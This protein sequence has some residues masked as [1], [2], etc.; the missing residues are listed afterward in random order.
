MKATPGFWFRHLGAWRCLSLRKETSREEQLGSGT[1]TY[2]EQLRWRPPWAFRGEMSGKSWSSGEELGLEMDI[3]EPSNYSWRPKPWEWVI[4]PQKNVHNERWPSENPAEHRSLIR[5][6]W[7]CLSPAFQEA[8][9]TAQLH[10]NLLLE[11]RVPQ[12]GSKNER[13]ITV[14]WERQQSKHKVVLYVASGSGNT[15]RS[16]D[17]SPE[18]PCGITLLAVS[19]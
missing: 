9:P 7:S 6:R 5:D 8:K 15:A 18:R 2:L 12:Q 10:A 3:W 1:W 4:L 17:T 11:D 14:R 16:W 19:L 13:E